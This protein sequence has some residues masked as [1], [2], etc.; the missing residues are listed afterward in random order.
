MK[1]VTIIGARPQI[2]KA[3]ALSRAIREEFQHDI[4][5]VIVHT[6]Q[7]YDENM[8]QVFFDELGI[9][10]PDVNLGV[11]S[12]SHGVQTARMIEGIEKVL[13][14][15]QPDA[16]VI[17][18]DT[19]STLAGT[20]AASKIHVPIVHIES[21]LRSYKKQMPEEINRI[22]TDHASTLLFTPT[23]AGLTNLEKEGFRVSEPPY[24]IDNP[25]V[26]HCGDIMYDNSLHYASVSDERSNIL[27]EL[28]LSPGNF[29][30]GTIHR[31][32]N[33]DDPENLA[34]IFMALGRISLEKQVILP[35]HPRTTNK[36]KGEGYEAV[37]KV[38][39]EYPNIRI[40]PPASFLDIIALEKHCY[41]TL[42]DSGGVQK[43]SFFFQRPCI[44]LRDETE[45]I[46]LVEQ[47]AALLAGSSEERILSAWEHF[48]DKGG[49]PETSQIFGDG[50]AAI[51]ICKT[52]LENLG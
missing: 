24:H 6:G 22:L 1:I 3:A 7:H 32:S 4:E 23:K 34:S 28:E 49:I 11:G 25:G 44:I 12:G 20:V 37:R 41:L 5:E 18:G 19:N 10:E 8:S 52:M 40:V 29:V 21:G 27:N 48:N 46:E 33:T 43:E 17:Y 51:F 9:P 47:G 39:D 45:W 14:E 16:L 35:L 38:L 42:T 50:K 30:L 13:I 31:P 2:I 36:I 15:E 26:F